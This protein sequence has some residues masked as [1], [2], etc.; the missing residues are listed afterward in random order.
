MLRNVIVS[1]QMPSLHSKW[2]LKKG[3]PRRVA[4]GGTGNGDVEGSPLEAIFL[5]AA[6]LPSATSCLWGQPPPQGCSA[7]QMLRETA[8]DICITAWINRTQVACLLACADP[9][10]QHERDSE[11]PAGPLSII[12]N[13]SIIHNRSLIKVILR[14]LSGLLPWG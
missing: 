1:V 4:L 6:C 7:R 14:H 11:V 10:P 8:G 2:F 12:N 13:V 5:P 3:E 9:P